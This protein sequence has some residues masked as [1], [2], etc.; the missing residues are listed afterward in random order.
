M[1][2]PASYRPA[3]IPTLPGVY[4]FS[5]PEGRVIYV[6]KA[7]NLRQRLSN[8]FRDPA[9]LAP[10]TRTMVHT[11]SEVRW[12]VVGTEV[13]ALTLEY[14]WIKQYAPRFNVIFRDDKSY[15]YL[16]L[17]MAEE[18]P[19]AYVTREA[20][21]K[22]V[23]YFGPYTHAWAIREVL[24][25]LLRVFPVRSCSAGVFRRAQ[26]QGRPCLLGYI[27]KCAAPCVGRI[28]APDH[29]AL[30]EQLAQFLAGDVGRYIA[31][32]ERAMQE[33]AAEQ[34]FE[35]AAQLRDDLAALRRVAER[36]AVVLP[37][38]TSADVFALATD[39]LH[40]SVQQYRVRHGRIVSQRG[41]V[42]DRPEDLDD[43]ALVTT[44]LTQ[45]YGEAVAAG[46]ADV[47][48]EVLVSAAPSE[49]LTEWLTGLRGSR[50]AVRVPQRGDKHQLV[51]TARTGAE[52]ALKA[53]KLRRGAD[54]NARS[55][56][57]RE[58]AAD[59]GMAQ[60]P[61]RIECYDISHTQGTYQ[62]GSMVVFE[63][64]LPKKRDYRTFN[65]RGADG[66]GARD[67]TEAIA[68]VLRRRFARRAGAAAAADVEEPSEPTSFAYAPGLLVI[69]GGAPQ[70]AAAA[71]VLAELGQ[72]IPVVGIAKRLEELW[73]PGEEFPL[74]LPRSSEALHLVQRVRDEAHR[75]AIT[76]HRQRRS[77]AMTVSALDGLPG[78]G[79]ARQRALLQAFGS[80]K[81]LR[82]ASSEEIAAVPGIGPV[83]AGEIH[84]HLHRA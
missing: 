67:D 80:V 65:V 11:A 84:Q 82:A 61:L 50:V 71:A 43:A 3:Y 51:L 49:D 23:R 45:V 74:V 78:V 55:Q 1:A 10:R 68:E 9:A 59:L 72:D 26:A 19:R 42:T 41:W 24:D 16:A 79:P 7:R 63:D 22:G 60:A 70:V 25:L 44:L 15:P 32:T 2:D 83:L 5:D 4:R 39:E 73:L 8:Y 53:E 40:A 54:L 35:R 30:A 57:L 33:A 12:T 21:R 75:F 28:S 38:R 36:N 27:D 77:K 62:V 81:R 37:Q 47:P 17:S 48:A 58:L 29:R 31:L 76:H 13:E 52:Q 18:F 69:D 14:T 34:D 56:A 64:G 66:E 46:A 6:G 20:H